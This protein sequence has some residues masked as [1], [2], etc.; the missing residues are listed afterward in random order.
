MAEPISPTSIYEA[1]KTWSRRDPGSPPTRQLKWAEANRAKLKAQSLVRTAIQTK[2]LKR[3]CCEVCGSFRVDAHHDDYSKPLVVRWLCRR[4][5]M[6][7]HSA[8]KRIA[9]G[10]FQIPLF[11]ERFLRQGGA[12]VG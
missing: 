7:W 10:T 8:E 3:G 5:H 12:N 1:K 9:A 11:E 6:L 2:K 4:H